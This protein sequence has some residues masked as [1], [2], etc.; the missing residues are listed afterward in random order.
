MSF[1]PDLDTASML[2]HGDRLRA[3][4]W[5]SSEH[6]F[7]RGPVPAAFVEALKRHVASAFQPLAFGGLH[8]CEFCGRCSAG[9]EAAQAAFKRDVGLAEAGAAPDPPGT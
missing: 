8:T 9:G 3:I 2:G 4:G 6:P 1:Y 5:L 7:P